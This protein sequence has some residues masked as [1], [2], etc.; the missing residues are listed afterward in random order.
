MKKLVPLMFAVATALAWAGGPSASMTDGEVRK[1]DK[2]NQKVTLKHGEI[3][4]LDMPG[5]TMVFRVKEPAMLDTLAPGDK[6]RFQAGKVDG[7]FVV[8]A[9]EAVK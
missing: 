9:I 8:T 5:M 4:N 3:K 7:G 6:V 1:V 2:A